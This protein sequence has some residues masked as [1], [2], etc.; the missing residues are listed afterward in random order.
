MRLLLTLLAQDSQVQ[1]Y[2]TP[3]HSQ[4]DLA[5]PYLQQCQRNPPAPQLRANIMGQCCETPCLHPPYAP[6]S[7]GP[8]GLPGRTIPRQQRVSLLARLDSFGM[9]QG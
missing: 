1:V 6:Q 3:T 7:S 5:L 9:K 8:D 4:G 2:V